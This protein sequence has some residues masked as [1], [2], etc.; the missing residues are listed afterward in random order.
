MFCSGLDIDAR[1]YF[2]AV[3]ITI[4]LPTAIKIFSW[5]ISALRWMMVNTLGQLVIIFIVMFTIGGCTGLILGNSELDL[6]L[7][8]SYFVVGHFHYVLSLGATI[9]LLCAVCACFQAIF[10]V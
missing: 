5:L 6:T 3:T 2:T 10:G 9:G 4:A 1:T 7:H 8:D